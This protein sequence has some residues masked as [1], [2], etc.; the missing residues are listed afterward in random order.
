MLFKLKNNQIVEISA[1]S[2]SKIVSD[3]IH[4]TF[5]FAHAH[6]N[7]ALKMNKYDMCAHYQ[8]TF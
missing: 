6:F 5:N 8:I 3:T 7:Q 2:D 1:Y 4:N